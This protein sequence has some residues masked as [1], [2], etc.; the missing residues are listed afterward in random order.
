MIL[1]IVQARSSSSRLPGK[2]LK[3]I[4]KKPMIIHEIERIQRSLF[5]GKVV[6]ATSNA[7]ND[8][9][10]SMICRQYGIEV[11]RGNLND[12]LDRY[13]QCAKQY[14][15]EHVVR[16]TGDCPLI[17]WKI[18]DAVI[19]KHIEENNDYTSNTLEVTYPDGLDVEIMKF[20]ILKNAWENAQLPSEREHVTPYIHQK[21]Q[22]FRLG[23]LKNNIDLSKMRWTVDELDDFA[24]VTKVYEY[25]YPSNKVFLM[26]DIVELLKRYPEIEKMNNSYQRNEGMN[27]SLKDDKIFLEEGKVYGRNIKETFR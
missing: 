7:C 14:Q 10:L 4:L 19:M 22:S 21:P 27:K 23:C 2:V 11:F 5:I 26:Q 20:S 9:E 15:P 16:L 6:L 24:A 13:Y 3:H 8:D 17:D 25:L 12:V 1:A 18:I